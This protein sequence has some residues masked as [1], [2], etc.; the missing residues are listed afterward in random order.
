MLQIPFHGSPGS[1]FICAQAL[2]T[3]DCP[4]AGGH[5]WRDVPE[6]DDGSVFVIS[7]AHGTRG[8]SAHIR[9]AIYNAAKVAQAL[10][11]GSHVI[12]SEYIG[13]SAFDVFHVYGR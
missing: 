3:H 4:N 8:A 7:D 12:V 1:G 13:T 11:E 9:S 2:V 6:A 10:G 5:S